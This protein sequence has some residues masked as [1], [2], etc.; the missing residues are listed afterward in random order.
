VLNVYGPPNANVFRDLCRR[1]GDDAHGC[2]LII[3]LTERMLTNL[4]NETV[5]TSC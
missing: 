4:N 5:V 1:I 2:S 3:T